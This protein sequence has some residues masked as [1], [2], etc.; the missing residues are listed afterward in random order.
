MI[1][2]FI[3][4]V[5]AVFYYVSILIPN[6]TSLINWISLSYIEPNVGNDFNSSTIS[7]GDYCFSKSIGSIFSISFFFLFFYLRFIRIKT[8][9]TI[10]IASIMMIII[11]AIEDSDSMF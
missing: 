2:Y 8:S 1:T 4:S 9:I 7:N 5:L 11:G 3:V 10:I 6:M